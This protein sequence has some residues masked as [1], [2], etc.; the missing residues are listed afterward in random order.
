M[1]V[2]GFWGWRLVACVFGLFSLICRL[3]FTFTGWF[4]G[5]DW[6]VFR[7]SWGVSSSMFVGLCGYSFWGWLG[8]LLRLF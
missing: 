2:F 4:L 1:Y 5:L 3:L 6:I 7:M 8:Y